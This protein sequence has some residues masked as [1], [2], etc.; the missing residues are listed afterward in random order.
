[1][2]NTFQPYQEELEYIQQQI[3]ETKTNLSQMEE[4]KSDCA[5]RNRI[6]AY[7]VKKINE[8]ESKFTELLKRLGKLLETTG[9]SNNR[10]KNFDLEPYLVN[11]IDQEI[12]LSQALSQLKNKANKLLVCLI[13]GDKEQSQDTFRDRIQYKIFKE[14]KITIYHLQFPDNLNSFCDQLQYQLAKKTLNSLSESNENIN[15]F[16]AQSPV[17]VMLYAN[18]YY[19]SWPKSGCDAIKRFLDFWETWPN[20]SPDQQIFVFLFI[21]YNYS[22]EQHNENVRRFW[23]GFADKKKSRSSREIESFLNEISLSEINKFSGIVLPR[24]QGITKQQALDWVQEVKEKHFP[25]DVYFVPDTKLEIET[26]FNQY[27]WK[28]K[29]LPKRIPMDELALSLRAILYEYTAESNHRERQS[30]PVIPPSEKSKANMTNKNENI[31]VPLWQRITA[32]AFGTSFVVV[33]LIIAI[34]I[35]SPTTFQIFVFRVVLSLAAGGVGAII[36]GF[37]NV[38]FKN[39]LRAGGALALFVLVYQ[40]NPPALISETSETSESSEPKREAVQDK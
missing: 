27:Q 21:N 39:W 10:S 8:Q 33:L 3:A 25:N 7:L 15:K 12:K 32:V 26:I 34:F 19:E 5:A 29:D 22:P 4:E 11:R 18:M 17:P 6:P 35:P 16:L 40:V 9:D 38:Q 13:H 20:L 31:T 36:P 24:L 23:L 2:S 30:K 37:I 1:M 14:T 28:S